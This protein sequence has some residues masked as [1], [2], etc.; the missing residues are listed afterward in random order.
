MYTKLHEKFGVMVGIIM[1]YMYITIVYAGIVSITEIKN[2]VR[3]LKLGCT[4]EQYKDMEKEMEK[5]IIGMKTEED[6]P[7]DVAIA[8]TMV[9][10]NT[11][12]KLSE[13]KKDIKIE[14]KPEVRGKTV[15]QLKRDS[16]I[17]MNKSLIGV[18]INELGILRLVRADL[19]ENGKIKVYETKET[20][21][22]NG[23]EF[24]E[25][26]LF[27]GMKSEL[28]IN[29]SIEKII[30]K[31]LN[32]VEL[33]RHEKRILKE[34]FTET[35][36]SEFV[37]VLNNIKLSLGETS[38]YNIRIESGKSKLNETGK[39]RI[40]ININNIGESKG[41]VDI[42]MKVDNKNRVFD[43]DVI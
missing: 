3:Y 6:K 15:E 28:S 35:G 16:L 27:I 1:F 18:Y 42:I 17:Y 10:D 21:T 12:A 41:V 24:R 7:Q 13:N 19:L 34:G 29:R 37:E 2:E 32:D 5:F 30:N 39:N 38:K 23:G 33:N 9:S 14:V 20:G 8:P 22:A 43:L 31:E 36:K 26:L 11:F 25:K 4:E 40:Y